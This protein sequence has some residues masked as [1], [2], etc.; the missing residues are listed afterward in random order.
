M[1][2]DPKKRKKINLHAKISHL[3]VHAYVLTCPTL[4]SIMVQ[5]IQLLQVIL[6]QDGGALHNLSTSTTR[7]ALR[8]SIRT[9]LTTREPVGEKGV[10]QSEI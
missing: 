3:S 6:L 9:T 5:L 1:S 2:G 10:S 4:I 8:P 7:T